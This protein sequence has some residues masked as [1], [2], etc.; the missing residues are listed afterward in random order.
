MATV[1]IERIAFPATSH[2]HAKEMTQMKKCTIRAATLW[3]AAMAGTTFA[4]DPKPRAA[5]TKGEKPKASPGWVVLQEDWSCPFLYDFSTSLHKAREHYRAKEDK[6][7]AAQI[8]KAIAWLNYAQ[9]HAEKSTAED[10]STARYDLMDFSASLKSG[11]PVTARKLDAAFADASIALA[12]H[13][14]FQAGKAL[15]DNDLKT[16]GRYMMAAADLLRNAAQSANIE[17]GTE[18]V[19]IFDDY[20]PHGYWDDTILFEK[21]KLETNL[22]TV[23]TELEKLATKLK[24]SK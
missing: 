8:D 24:A 18:A 22:T 20:A 17:Y 10:L 4:E 2:T 23:K 7:A 21:S 1:P 5:T 16:A 19:S 15:A 13:H 14:H 12:K 3:F 6:S 11:K 9:D